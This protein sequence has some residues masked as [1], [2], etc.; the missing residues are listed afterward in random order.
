MQDDN[1]PYS[2]K[3]YTTHWNDAGLS[4]GQRQL[5]QEIPITKAYVCS[6]RLQR[7]E[8]NF[9]EAKHVS[10]TAPGLHSLFAKWHL[11]DNRL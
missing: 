1:A 8:C 3:F 11:P 7:K 9:V 5:S 6:H 4:L 2:A 10:D